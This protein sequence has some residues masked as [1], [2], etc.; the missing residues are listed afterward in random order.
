MAAERAAELSDKVVLVVPTRSQQAGLTAAVA[1]DPGRAAEENG[2]NMHDAIVELSIGSVAPAARDDVHGRFAAG[3]A[4]GFVDEQ[5]IA[6]GEPEATLEAVIRSLARDAEIV[7]CIAGEGAPVADRRA[8]RRWR[9]TASSSRCATAASP[10]TGGCSPPSSARRGPPARRGSPRARTRTAP[11]PPVEAA[12]P[13]AAA[14]TAG[15]S[16]SGQREQRGAH[17]AAVL[18]RRLLAVEERVPDDLHEQHA[19]GARGLVGR[20]AGVEQDRA[21]RPR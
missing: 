21:W 2:M 1:L 3:E 8:S 19:E 7:T 9:P 13:S 5:I 10:P 15:N 12:R 18:G 17:A 11:S 6:W 20:E 16:S 4:V 14:V